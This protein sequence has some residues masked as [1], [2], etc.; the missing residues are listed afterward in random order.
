MEQVPLY[1]VRNFEG[2]ACEDCG[3]THAFLTTYLGAC[4]PTAFREE[5]ARELGGNE[6]EETHERSA[7]AERATE[8]PPK[9]LNRVP[10]R[11]IPGPTMRVR[12]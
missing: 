11:E 12:H 6:I 7:V 2:N 3:G 8:T 1:F 9:L 4:V 10:P 5:R